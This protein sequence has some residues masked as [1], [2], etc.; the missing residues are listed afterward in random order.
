MALD[1]Y[2]LVGVAGSAAVA[3]LFG[4]ALRAAKGASSTPLLTDHLAYIETMGY[5]LQC[6]NGLWAVTCDGR[7]VGLPCDTSRAAIESAALQSLDDMS[8][9]GSVGGLHG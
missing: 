7:V 5:S 6:V 8:G 1:T 4:Y 9:V 2:Y 3:A